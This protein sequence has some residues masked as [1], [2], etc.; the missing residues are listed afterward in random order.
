M[1]IPADELLV[2]ACGIFLNI[3]ITV[4]Y[5][6]GQWSTLNVP[7]ITHNLAIGLSDIHLAYLGNCKFSLLCKNTEL[8]TKA[9]KLFNRVKPSLRHL[10]HEKELY[11]SIHHL[12]DKNTCPETAES[13]HYY[14]DS[15]DTEI[16]EIE[17]KLI[18]TITFIN[19][20][21][22]TLPSNTTTTKNTKKPIKQRSTLAY[23]KRNKNMNFKCPAT[24]CQTRSETRKAIDLHYKKIH[25]LT[26]YCTLCTKKL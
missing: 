26:H 9:R 20:M 23:H 19:K 5:T 12:D 8:H 13:S 24:D 17:E 18:G 10:T 25:V 14:P 7:N 2:F 4:D 6:T 1:S 11:I 16:Y 22:K 3:H 21:E 15:E